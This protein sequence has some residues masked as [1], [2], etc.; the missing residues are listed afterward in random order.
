MAREDTAENKLYP[1][2]QNSRT[3]ILEVSAE[4]YKRREIRSASLPHWGLLRATCGESD[5]R[6]RYDKEGRLLE[7][8]KLDN[9]GTAMPSI[10]FEL[11][12]AGRPLKLSRVVHVNGQPQHE[13]L[14]VRQ[15]FDEHVTVTVVALS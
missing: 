10:R 2:K 7:S 8:T 14:I 12:P 4:I 5:I 1:S 15:K 9:A 11:D 13:Q 6:Y 3:S